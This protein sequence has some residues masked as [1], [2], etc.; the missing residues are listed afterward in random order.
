VRT[1]TRKAFRFRI[2]LN[3]EQRRILE[4]TLQTCRIL[5]NNLLA[6]H[7][8]TKLAI[9]RRKADLVL[10]I[11]RL[12]GPQWSP[13]IT[14]TN[15][16]KIMGLVAE[17]RTLSKYQGRTPKPNLGLRRSSLYSNNP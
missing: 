9:T 7:R 10:E 16:D 8:G 13:Q 3:G 14:S 17:L 15:R 5:Y 1:R 4:R 6:E 2:Y 12:K 11:M